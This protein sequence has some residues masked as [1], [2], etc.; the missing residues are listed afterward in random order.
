M[1]I[2]DIIKNYKVVGRNKTKTGEDRCFFLNEIDNILYCFGPSNYVRQAFDEKDKEKIL[3]IEYENG[4][5]LQV[6]DNV[7][8]EKIIQKFELF[9]DH[10]IPITAMHLADKLQIQTKKK[11]RNKKGNTGV[12]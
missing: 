1:T 11:K 8:G 2:E 9:T 7:Y 5:Y 10:G 12:V 6:G 4:P 3:I